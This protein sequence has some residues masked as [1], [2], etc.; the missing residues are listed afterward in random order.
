MSLAQERHFL[1]PAKVAIFGGSGKQGAVFSR[2][3]SEHG[4]DV[5]VVSRTPEKLSGVKGFSTNSDYKETR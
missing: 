2:I 4:A 3:L 5:V 1:T